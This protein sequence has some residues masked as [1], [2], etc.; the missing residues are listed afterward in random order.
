MKSKIL[1]RTF[2]I[3]LLT[4]FAVGQPSSAQDIDLK[5]YRIIYNFN[6]VKQSDNTRL[7]EVN[8]S[9]RNK[10]NRKDRMPIYQ[11]EI[12][13]INVLDDQEVL[14][15]KSMT[16]EEGHAALILPVNQDY[17]TDAEGYINIRAQF[18][19]SEK[20]KKIKKE[21][22]VQDLKMELTLNEIDSL[23][24][25]HLKAY[26]IDSVGTMVPVNG[27]TVNIG[28]KS[29]LAVMP[30]E[31]ARTKNGEYTFEFPDDIPGDI[32]G[33]I[34]VNSF[35]DDHDDYGT[36]NMEESVQW[37]SP[38]EVIKEEH[39]LWTTAAPYWMYIVLTIMLVGVW[40]NYGYTIY[41]LIKLKKEGGKPEYN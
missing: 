6:T 4:V 19:G 16:S 21:I 28:V 38:K 29:M 35:L 15:G 7:L 24:T 34:T 40:A 36:V 41:N 9:A 20:L 14:L 39:K 23:K 26:T 32:N 25:V 8:F 11:A 17:L 10:K 22:R 2:I 31:E 33:N 3:T 27:L 18:D 5:K 12:K 13:F 1:K 37:G 30:I